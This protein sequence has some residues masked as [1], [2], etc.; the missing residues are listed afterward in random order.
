MSPKSKYNRRNVT[1]TNTATLNTA[2]AEMRP[3]TQTTS[4]KTPK[5]TASVN[6]FD[7]VVASQHFVSEIKWISIV[8][9]IIIVLMI[10]SY[11][12]FR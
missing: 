5:A 3:E 7:M 10:A 12:I 4:G 2:N 8:T 11:L 6:A 9:V 1:Q